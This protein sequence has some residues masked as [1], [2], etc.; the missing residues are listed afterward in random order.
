MPDEPDEVEIQTDTRRDFV[1]KNHLRH[2]SD[3]DAGS[4]SSFRAEWIAL[5]ARIC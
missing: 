1:K 4:E 2:A 3:C 5:P